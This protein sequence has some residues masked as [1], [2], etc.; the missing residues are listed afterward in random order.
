MTQTLRN[1]FLGFMIMATFSLAFI[2]MIP[3]A[4]AVVGDGATSNIQL[5]DTNTNGKIDNISFEIANPNNETWSLA[6]VAPYGLSVTDGG[7]DV[8]ITSVVRSSITAFSNPIT[9]QI[10]LNE[11]DTDLSVDTSASAVELVYTQVTG[12]QTCT[13]CIR[14]NTDEEMN[15][16]ATGDGS[17]AVNTENDSAVPVIVTGV[18]S[19][20]SSNGTVDQVVLTYSEAVVFEYEASDWTVTIPGTVTLAG[21]Y[22]TIDCLGNTTATITCTDVDNSSLTAALNVTGGSIEPVWVYNNTDADNSVTDVGLRVAL[23]ESK[24]LVDGA[25]PILVSASPASGGSLV[26][27][28]V[29]FTLTFSEDLTTSA[30][31]TSNIVVT[32]STGASTYTLV[33]SA[34]VVTVNPT[35]ASFSSGATVTVTVGV[36]VVDAASNAYNTSGAI[37]TE[38]YSFT[39]ITSSGGGGGGTPSTVVIT[40]DAVT[41]TAPNG[42]EALTGGSA[43][44]VT[45]TSTGNINNVNLSYSLDGGVTFTTIVAGTDDDGSYTWT[46]PN[47]VATSVLLRAVGRDSGGATL[48]TDL[49]DASFSV[50]LNAS[51]PTQ[52]PL[53]PAVTVNMQTPSGGMLEMI[54]GTLFRGVALPDVYRVNE[55]G[56]RFVFPNETTFFSWGYSFSNVVVVNDVEL[57]KLSLGGRVT[58]KPGSYLV[59]IQ[60]DP[61]VY[62][63]SDGAILHH[64]PSE[65]KAASLYGANWATMVRDIP[66]VFFHDYTIGEPLTS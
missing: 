27:A 41:L 51:L 38:P 53:T 60:S 23:G 33:E 62:Q 46:V 50:S 11:E 57:Q 2:V 66:V 55:N 16:I 19:D 30:E 37:V 20:S 54:P 15:T 40:S 63:I 26:P 31:S 64:V 9:I 32:A 7:L 1:L 52:T 48:A 36:G 43:S 14:D 25:R 13:N 61:K 24:T 29:N 21:D 22:Q 65:A 35:G 3:K 39:A 34:G 18:Y 28:T 45:W 49:S 59:K 47:M 5:F 12:D 10:S 6:G 4:Q 58:I 56:T 44:T 17:G 42:G 8:T